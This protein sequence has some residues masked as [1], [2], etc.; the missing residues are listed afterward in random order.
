MLPPKVKMKVKKNND[1]CQ[2]KTKNKQRFRRNNSCIPSSMMDLIVKPI[3]GE[4]KVKSTEGT[5]SGFI[6]ILK[7]KY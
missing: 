1:I 2:D 4:L 5:G 3:E 7:L 6:I